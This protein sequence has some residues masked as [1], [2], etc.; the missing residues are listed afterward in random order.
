MGWILRNCSLEN[1][2]SER[3]MLIIVPP[4]ELLIS[5]KVPCGERHCTGVLLEAGWGTIQDSPNSSFPEH[6]EGSIKGVPWR[7]F[8]RISRCQ[9]NL[10]QGSVTVLLATHE[11]Q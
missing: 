1:V 9:Q 3:S 5:V 6:G 10:G 2:P 8:G 4:T 7:I 11:K